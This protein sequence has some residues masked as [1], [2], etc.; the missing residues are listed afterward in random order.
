MYLVTE[1]CNLYVSS[2]RDLCTEMRRGVKYT[3]CLAHSFMVCLKRKDPIK[4]RYL[5]LTGFPMGMLLTSC[6]LTT[7]GIIKKNYFCFYLSLVLL[8]FSSLYLNVKNTV[9]RIKLL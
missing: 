2:D 8:F 6:W 5:D 1:I 9:N 3:T 4:L 7:W